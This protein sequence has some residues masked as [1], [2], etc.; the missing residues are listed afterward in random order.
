[1]KKR[2]KIFLIIF[3]NA[4]GIITICM[5]L[6]KKII[7]AQI[8]RVN[9]FRS[10]YNVLNSWMVIKSKGEKLVTYFHNN[11][12]RNIAIYGMGEIGNRLYEELENTEIEVV[13]GIDSNSNSA[14]GKVDIYSIDDKMPEV[15]AIIVT[16]IFAYQDIK[17]NL[18]KRVSVPII[19][20]EEVTDFLL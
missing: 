20:L 12:Y 2:L 17:E 11:N 15:D 14:Y 4:L 8:Y 7:N 19:S 16:P 13:Y 10:Y 18:E 9:K 3:F 5:Y 1:M 6:F